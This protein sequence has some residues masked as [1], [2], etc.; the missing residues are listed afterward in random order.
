MPIQRTDQLHAPGLAPPKTRQEVGTT[1]TNEDREDEDGLFA[2]PDE[3]KTDKETEQITTV[4]RTCSA[5]YGPFSKRKPMLLSV[6]PTLSNQIPMCQTKSEFRWSLAR[7]GNGL[8]IDL[9]TWFSCERQQQQKKTL[10]TGHRTH[11]W[12]SQDE[13]QNKKPKPSQ[14][15]DAKQRDYMG[16]KRYN[17]QNASMPLE[18]IQMIEEH[19][20]WL[21]PS[22]MVPKS[23][24]I[25]EED[26]MDIFE[27]ENLLEEVE[28]LAWGMKK[29]AKPLKGNI[30]EVGMD[31]TCK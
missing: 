9:L 20:E 30:V 13:A 25:S 7:F 11:Y 18:T 21:T 26:E 15:P 31:A 6:V 10:K 23:V 17:F 19:V 24:T 27:I 28:M 16:M 29:I 3:K 8:A 2:E 4:T 22:A 5:H 12:C 1:Q 14:K